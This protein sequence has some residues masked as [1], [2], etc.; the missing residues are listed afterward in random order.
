MKFSRSIVAIFGVT[1]VATLS[2]AGAVT[3]EQVLQTTLEKNARATIPMARA[4]CVCP[5]AAVLTMPATAHIVITARSKPF[6]HRMPS[7]DPP[8]PGRVTL[9]T[10]TAS[11]VA[12]NTVS[13]QCVP[14]HILAWL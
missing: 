12:P 10:V 1:F 14:D 6:T 8:T 4:A 11:R 2:R 3:L 5:S 9:D 7:N 13:L